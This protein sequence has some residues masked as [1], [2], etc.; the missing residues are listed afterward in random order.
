[1][2]R[3]I[4]Y[5]QHYHF[6]VL[7]TLLVLLRAII[8]DAMLK[9]EWLGLSSAAWFI[10]AVAVPVAHQI[11]VWL[12]WRIELYGQRLTRS[13]GRAAFPAASMESSRMPIGRRIFV[14]IV[15]VSSID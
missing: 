11:Y 3:K 10:I 1:M 2:L 14:L 5:R 13:L 15:R 7:A 8:D 4:F 12:F 6:L 9:G